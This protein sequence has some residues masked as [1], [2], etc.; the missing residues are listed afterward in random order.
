[1]H[2]GRPGVGRASKFGS[3]HDGDVFCAR[4]VT[5]LAGN[6]EEKILFV[7]LIIP[8]RGGGVAAKTAGDFGLADGA[9]HGFVDIRN[10][11]EGASRREV[12]IVERRKKGDTRF[13]IALIGCA[14]K[15]RLADAPGTEGP[16]QSVPRE[17]CR[18]M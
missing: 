15:V 2:V 12:E 8:D 3:L 13:A 1:M 6:T 14:E 16:L 4:A 18:E 11:G 17:F 9:I 7:D 10:G 5:G